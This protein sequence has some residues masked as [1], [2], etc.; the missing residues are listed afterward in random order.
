[1]SEGGAPFWVS[2]PAIGSAS[3]LRE[4]HQRRIPDALKDGTVAEIDGILLSRRPRQDQKFR[5]DSLLAVKLPDDGG[6]GGPQ[7]REPCV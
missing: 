5:H 4:R 2:R 7:A 3:K 6:A 1:M